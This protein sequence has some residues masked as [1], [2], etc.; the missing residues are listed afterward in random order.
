MDSLRALLAMSLLISILF[1]APQASAENASTVPGAAL[2]TNTE[3]DALLDARDWTRLSPLLLGPPADVAAFRRR[4][5]WLH[6]KLDRGAGF[7][8]AYA[9][10]RNLWVA[11]NAAKVDDPADD[12][13]VTAGMMALYAYELIVIDGAKCEDRSA[14]SNRLNQ[15]LGLNPATFSFLKG[16]PNELKEKLATVAVAFEKRTAPLRRDDDLLCRG[17]F[18][19]IRAGAAK[20]TQQQI[21]NTQ[22][23]G[24]T[25]AVTP[26]PDWTPKFLSSQTYI[27]IQSRARATMREALLKVIQ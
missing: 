25:V 11:G 13:R 22:N 5:D 23:Y 4:L 18:D 19:E 21:P 6:V 10:M 27:P 17:G 24:T 16:R 8:V 9:Y 14:P 15:L 12:L 20:G 2:P 1:C 3:L 7:L 26:P